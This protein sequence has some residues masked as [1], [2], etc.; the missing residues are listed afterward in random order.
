[1]NKLILLLILGI[2]LGCTS[3][4][5]INSNKLDNSMLITSPMFE[6]E[7]EIPIQYTCD[8]SDRI[9]PLIFHEVPK[10]AKALVLIVDDPDAPVGTWDHWILFNIPPAIRELEGDAEPKVPHGTNSWKRTNWGGPCPPDKEHRYF[11]KLYAL[12]TKLDL[13]EGSTKKEIESAMKG[14]VIAEAQL[15]GRYK[16]KGM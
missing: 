9:V 8:G 15:M 13:P 12:D 2:L 11:F 3:Q 7:E 14:H 1:M 6:N 16:R 4:N 10:S 5:Y